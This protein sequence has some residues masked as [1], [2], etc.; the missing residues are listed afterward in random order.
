M[1]AKIIG[2]KIAKARK[3]ANMS[4]AQLAQQLFISPQAVG[5]W[6]RGESVPDIITMNRLAPILGVDLN[7]FSEHFLSAS[8]DA[9]ARE[10]AEEPPAAKPEN[11]HSWD[12]SMGNWV[13]ADFSGLKHLHEKFSSSNMQRCKFI[14]ADLSG[15]LLKGNH[16]VSCDFSEADISNSQFQHSHLDTNLFKECSLKAAEFSGSH[17]KSCNFSG[18]DLTG[19]VFKSSS[20]QK[21]TMVDA[22]LNGTAFISSSVA[23]LVFE[24]TLTDCAFDNCGFSRVTFQNSTLINTFFKCRSLKQLRFVDCQT[25]RITYEFL[26]SGKAD[27]SGITL[28]TA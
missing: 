28:L 14:G 5:K 16:I 20:F 7:Y 21:N 19:V 27:V 26:K 17:I 6:E 25:D 1:E 13:D 4:Q 15:L 3:E 24:G 10:F 11:K 9:V 22:V 8:A 23:D 2:N 18:A 12:M